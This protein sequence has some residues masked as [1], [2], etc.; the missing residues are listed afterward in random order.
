MPFIED[1]QE[2]LL[3]FASVDEAWTSEQMICIEVRSSGD[4]TFLVKAGVIDDKKMLDVQSSHTQADVLAC[5]QAAYVESVQAMTEEEAVAAFGPAGAKAHPAVRVA[6]IDTAAQGKTTIMLSHD[7]PLGVLVAI[8]VELHLIGMTPKK[9]ETA[10]PLSHKG[11]IHPLCNAPSTNPTAFVQYLQ[12]TRSAGLAGNLSAMVAAW[13]QPQP[14]GKKKCTCFACISDEQYQKVL[15]AAN[16]KQSAEKR[17]AGGLDLLSLPAGKKNAIEPSTGALLSMARDLVPPRDRAGTSAES[18]IV[19]ADD[20]ASAR[21]HELHTRQLNDPGLQV[22]GERSMTA[23]ALH[24]RQ[25]Q[26]VL[27]KGDR[28]GL[29]A[30]M[31]GSGTPDAKLL[32]GLGSSLPAGHGIGRPLVA[33]GKQRFSNLLQTAGGASPATPVQLSTPLPDQWHTAPPSEPQPEPEADEEEAD[34]D[35]GDGGSTGCELL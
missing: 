14:G 26:E 12:S 29:L 11:R 9:I 33:L 17:P 3:E 28:G 1:E 10:N 15:S 2:L 35:V 18:S 4:V 21:L 13:T 27:K 5:L 16:A 7:I 25:L 23:Q 8:G 24:M 6:G 20:D 22:G 19:L 34:D 31:D 32:R 30:L